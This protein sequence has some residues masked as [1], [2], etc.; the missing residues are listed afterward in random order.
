MDRLDGVDYAFQLFAWLWTGR[1]SHRAKNN[2][3]GGPHSLYGGSR[4]GGVLGNLCAL[5]RLSVRHG[6]WLDD[7]SA[8]GRDDHSLRAWARSPRASPGS[9]GGLHRIGEDD[10]TD[11]RRSH[12]SN[13]GLENSVS[14]QLRFW[15]RHLCDYVLDL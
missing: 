15:S 7:G 8:Y 11:N 5:A 14:C 3:Q 6:A 9:A 1:R 2:L 13:L 4:L 12:S 10:W